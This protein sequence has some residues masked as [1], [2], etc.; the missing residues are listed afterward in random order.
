MKVRTVCVA[1]PTF[2]AAGDVAQML[3]LTSASSF[4][5]RR[6]RLEDTLGFPAPVPWSR[7]PMMWRRES[8]QRW[9]DALGEVPSAAL[10]LV[11]DQADAA[12]RVVM[13]QQARTV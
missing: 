1:P 12:R 11:P 4:L 5:G 6:A 2:V 9:V 8:V 13:L 7:R 10:K 3:G